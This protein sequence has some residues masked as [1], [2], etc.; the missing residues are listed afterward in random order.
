MRDVDP[1]APSVG[2]RVLACTSYGFWMRADVVSIR[3]ALVQV[4]YVEEDPE[5]RWLPK[6]SGVLGKETQSV[7]PERVA[8]LPYRA[9]S[10]LPAPGASVIALWDRKRFHKGV[11]VRHEGGR[12]VVRFDEGDE[13]TFEAADVLPCGA[14]IAAEVEA[15]R[16]R[17]FEVGKAVRTLDTS[18]NRA[19]GWISE[20]GSGRLYVR[21]SGVSWGL[22][23]AP[24]RVTHG[25]PGRRAEPAP[26]AAPAGPGARARVRWLDR[27]IYDATVLEAPG[28][29]GRIE[30]RY[31]DGTEQTVP[32]D[33]VAI[34]RAA[35][36]Q[37]AQARA[38]AALPPWQ[39][40]APALVVVGSGLWAPATV[41]ATRGSQV[42]VAPEKGPPIWTWG[43]Q[44]AGRPA[45]RERFL[46]RG[47]R[48][49]AEVV[50]ERTSKRGKVTRAVERRAGRAVDVLGDRLTVEFG[51]EQSAF[52]LEQ[53]WQRGAPLKGPITLEATAADVERAPDA[54]EPASVEGTTTD[55][56]VRVRYEK[57][58]KRATV[59]PI[60][61]RA[62]PT[63][64]VPVRGPEPAPPPPPPEPA[65]ADDAT[66]TMLRAIAGQWGDAGYRADALA[67]MRVDDTAISLPV[68]R[69]TLLV[70]VGGA[71]ADITADSGEGEVLPPTEAPLVRFAGWLQRWMGGPVGESR[72]ERDL[73]WARALCARED[74]A[75]HRA[76]GALTLRV[77]APLEVDD[78]LRFARAAHARITE[79]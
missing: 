29:D 1:V 28:A 73:A 71:A 53:I 12:A 3:G 75:A 14:P 27:E 56:L 7:A 18:G 30:V 77:P 15:L 35:P 40:G 37:V 11:V 38:P 24:D 54:W 10:T 50:H 48:V 47:T 46:A 34:V 61:V 63:E 79:D 57:D 43:V 41:L 78:L 9:P 55:G 42:F 68:E 62:R 59:D 2:S 33:R 21:Y 52:T 64:P 49:V 31:D 74:V 66:T 20:V 6:L 13:S 5:P 76:G 19:D 32:Q 26:M 4:R 44:I 58:R 16:G 69:G 23:I 36:P 25:G 67:R 39:K 65:V 22:W 45:D 17:G 70:R 72:A 51:D 60:R 8:R